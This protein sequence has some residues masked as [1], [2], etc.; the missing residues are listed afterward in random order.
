[1]YTG[2][3]CASSAVTSTTRREKGVIAV[4]LPRLPHAVCK[5]LTATGAVACCDAAPSFVQDTNQKLQAK[6]RDAAADSSSA[7]E[8]VSSLQAK[9]AK[10]Q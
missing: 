10:Q 6:V 9:V 5:A 2:L 4:P 3:Q 7:E 1:M 8:Q